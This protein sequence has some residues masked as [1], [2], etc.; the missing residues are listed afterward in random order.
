[1]TS[2]IA[3]TAPTEYGLLS[4]LLAGSTA[5]RRHLTRL[6]EQAG[7]GRIADTYAGLGNGA[8]I[9]LDLRPQVTA[10][11]T[12]QKNID[13][14]TTRLGVTQTAMTQLQQIASSFLANLNNLNGLN[15]SAVD[16]VAA[17]AR[18][19]LSQAASLLDTRDGNVYVFAGQDGEN[20]PV[21][22]PDTIASSGFATQIAAAV[23]GLTTSGAAATA[24]ATLAIASSNAPGT[25]PF[26]AYL[27]QPAGALQVPALQTGSTQIQQVGLVASANTSVASTGPSTT[28]SYTRD[29]MRALAT[30]GS[31]SSTQI[32]DPNFAALIQDTRASLTGAVGAMADRKSVV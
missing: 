3:G 16:S 26:S 23:A 19:A 7:S 29:L 2:Y 20:P 24:A 4:Q 15:P 21:P 8:S 18:S 27:S 17:D 5:V 12:Q 31:L 9:S 13:A 6:T 10:L 25:S 22:N 32:N 14:A 11:Q 30:L 1:M 28:G